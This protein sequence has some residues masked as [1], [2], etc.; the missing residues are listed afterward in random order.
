M[1]RK[2]WRFTVDESGMPEHA[3]PKFKWVDDTPFSNASPDL[4]KDKTEKTI[5]SKTDAILED[6]NFELRKK[7][8]SQLHHYLVNSSLEVPF[9]LERTMDQ[10]VTVQHTNGKSALI[11]SSVGSLYSGSFYH[12]GIAL[13]H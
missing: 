11:S 2:Q 5:E 12:N 7:P 10:S 13:P 1:E 3:R 9:F 6:S 8:N 4:K